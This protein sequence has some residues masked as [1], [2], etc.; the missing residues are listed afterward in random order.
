MTDDTTAALEAA[1]AA[2]GEAWDDLHEWV[3]TTK[4]SRERI[5]IEHRHHIGHER[6]MAATEAIRGRIQA[7]IIQVNAALKERS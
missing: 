3:R 6:G 4:Y 2:L 7:A 1:R 5:P